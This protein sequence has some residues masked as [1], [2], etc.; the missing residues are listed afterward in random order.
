MKGKRAFNADIYR[1]NVYHLEQLFY[2]ESIRPVTHFHSLGLTSVNI[3]YIWNLCDSILKSRKHD[4][5]LMQ[6]V[7]SRYI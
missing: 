4:W 5:D 3:V 2:K 7:R 6:L 1:R